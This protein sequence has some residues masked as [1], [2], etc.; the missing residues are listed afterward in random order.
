MIQRFPG[1]VTSFLYH[2]LRR[3]A[4]YALA[5]FFS[6]TYVLTLYPLHFLLGD[7]AFFESEDVAQHISGWLAYAA[8]DWHW[9]IFFTNR[10]GYPD[11][12]SIAFTDSI[13]LIAVFFKLFA[14]FLPQNFHYF[15]L[16]QGFAFFSQGIAAV[17]LMRAL[18]V[19]HL[20][21]LIAAL[22]FALTWP[23]LMWRMGHT[24]LMTH[25]LILTALGLY[26]HGRSG[27]W[28]FKKTAASFTILCTLA[29]LIH[30]Y[31]IPLCFLIFLAYI[32]DDARQTGKWFFN[33]RWALALVVLIIMLGKLLGYLGSSIAGGGFGQF[34]LNLAA[35][36]CG[37]HFTP[38]F[39]DATGGQGEGYNYLGIGF[40]FLAVIGL[41]LYRE[42]AFSIFKGSPAL[43]GI[44][45]AIFFYALSN[46]VYF[47]QHLLLDYPL[48]RFARSLASTFRASGRF[49]WVV[50]Y[51]LLFT[52]LSMWLK[53]KRR[54]VP[55]IMAIAIAAQLVDV[56]PLRDRLIMA[57]QRPGTI[58]ENH[59][60]QIL[61]DVDRISI[62]PIFGCSSADS[63][64]YIRYQLLA[65]RH[66][67]LLNT[68]YIARAT[69]N[70][71]ERSKEFNTAL[72]D[73][74]LYVL[75]ADY[76]GKPTFM[77]PTAF[78]KAL[79]HENC[80][81]IE[82][83]VLCRSDTSS[84]GW[85]SKGIKN[86]SPD[87]QRLQTSH[88]WTASEL[89]TA[90]GV[91]EK[92]H[93]LAREGSPG[94]LSFGPYAMISAGAYRIS[95]GYSSLKE[96]LENLN[97]WDIVSNKGKNSKEFAKGVFDPVA[98]KDSKKTIT[99]NL[100]NSTEGLEIRT[101][102]QGKGKFSIQYILIE[103]I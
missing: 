23:S 26:F 43:F 28:S 53:E 100:D 14:K 52:V 10:I 82:V 51:L 79:H 102:F 48:P 34:S 97:T 66:K 49:F 78:V 90:V 86:A 95:I 24:S 2:D 55:L 96:D 29:L 18:G 62:Y 94:Y 21:S 98:G 80:V 72:A 7:A 38:C 8:D 30:P 68:A 39:R 92:E 56:K 91:L 83:A 59:W 77:L 9:P 11:G 50:G 35:P 1:N 57:A 33:L 15:G 89:P 3:N 103:K 60:E 65:A 81:Q 25:A 85:K 6:T 47:Q 76:L 20:L 5:A 58:D 46:K 67:K 70:C 88:R 45:L 71:E 37:G 84:D 54:Y 19:C 17:F 63:N 99:L 93:L 13:P 61:A 75:P 41:A 64:V 73:R 69:A 42:K 4:A 22:V 16:W 12:I 31:F 40:F 27:Y 32:I 74:T 36:F 87:Y 101:Y 44:A